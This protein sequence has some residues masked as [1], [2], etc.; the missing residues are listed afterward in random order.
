MAINQFADQ[1]SQPIKDDPNDVA[2]EDSAVASDDDRNDVTDDDRIDTAE[3]LT[4]KPQF[5][6]DL[7]ANQKILIEQNEKIIKELGKSN[8]FLQ[9]IAKKTLVEES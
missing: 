5:I 9:A 6:R 7:I 3:L 1:S 8:G 2:R 4:P